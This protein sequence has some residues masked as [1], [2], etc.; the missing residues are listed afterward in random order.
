MSVPIL[1]RRSP[2]PR[3]YA[4]AAI[5]LIALALALPAAVSPSDPL[6]PHYVWTY[7]ADMELPDADVRVGSALVRV[8][9]AGVYLLFLL[10]R[11]RFPT[12]RVPVVLL[13]IYAGVCGVPDAWTALSYRPPFTGQPE[14][15]AASAALAGLAS[16]AC[17]FLFVLFLHWE[18]NPPPDFRRKEPAD[19]SL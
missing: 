10:T 15:Y 16:L 12:L 14:M 18:R 6:E 13:L 4:V 5:A 9:I 2:N 19:A 1:S 17:Q 11:L 8:F 7:L 3:Y